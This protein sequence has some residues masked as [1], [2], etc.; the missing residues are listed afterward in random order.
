[1]NIAHELLK[2]AKALV[3][4]RV[5][6]TSESDAIRVSRGRSAIR[7]WDM[8]N[9][10]RRGK[11]VDVIALYDLD[12]AVHNST[13]EA[14]VGGKVED[15]AQKI[16]SA[17]SFSKAEKMLKDA[18]KAINEVSQFKVSIYES[19]ERGVDVPPAGFQPIEVNGKH[20]YVRSGYK[21]F[22]VRD[23]DDQYNEP[24]CIPAIKGGKRDVQV[25]Y[26]WVK[27]NERKI[28]NMSFSE[29]TKAMGQAGIKYHYYCA[30]D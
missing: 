24:T 19:T 6:E 25:F 20:V 27:D 15:L 8:E 5:G 3:A 26:R 14:N 4:V 1:M 12:Y 9:A 30:V 22:T 16:M 28:P 29:V 2:V 21:D 7:V 18:E 10:G 17:N 13:Q 23:K 11:K